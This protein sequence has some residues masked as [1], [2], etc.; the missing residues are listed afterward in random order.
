MSVGGWSQEK[1][2]TYAEGVAKL[3]G[4]FA[5]LGSGMQSRFQP[6]YDQAL[7][8][9]S[10]HHPLYGGF[11]KSF[12]VDPVNVTRDADRVD[13]QVFTGAAFV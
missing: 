4:L 9:V 3:T 13:L 1:P 6:A 5:A 11:S 10:S 8:W 2:P 12:Y 7:A